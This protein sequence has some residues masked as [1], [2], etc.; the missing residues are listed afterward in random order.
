MLHKDIT[1]AQNHVAYSWAVADAAALA[2]LSLSAADEGKIAWQLDIGAFLILEDSA[3][4]TWKDITNGAV[5]LPSGGAVSH[6]LQKSSAADYD[7]AWGR[8]ANGSLAQMAAATL[9]GNITGS[10]ANAADIS[11]DDVAT[12]VREYAARWL[13]PRNILQ[14]QAGEWW[15]PDTN[16]IA[17][18]F[19][20]AVGNSIDLGP[21]SIP[22]STT[23]ENIAVVWNTGAAASKYKIVMY[24]SNPTTGY[25]SNKLWESAECT[26]ADGVAV[27]T[28]FGQAMVAG[29]TYWFGV[30]SEATRSIGRAQGPTL[31]SLGIS[32][33]GDLNRYAL[34]R[35]TLTY[36]S[37]PDSATA[38]LTGAVTKAAASPA[39]FRFQQPT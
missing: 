36:S 8:V 22:H 37:T 16:F 4:P 7:V 6:V 30:W 1:P 25:P 13:A 29:T 27:T 2:A 23:P 21:V 32:A 28:A 5:G 3:G 12:T 35:H 17:T 31:A 26:V 34:L 19:G 20:N 24:E 38:D 15:T 11:M 9:K 39:S 18:G 14:P 10:T 33:P